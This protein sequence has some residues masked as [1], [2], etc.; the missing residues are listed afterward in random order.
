MN[1]KS[2]LGV[3][4]AWDAS[5]VTEWF[6]STSPLKLQIIPNKLG[7]TFRKRYLK[8][9]L[10]PTPAN[11][12]IGLT[13]NNLLIGVLGFS[14]FGGFQNAPSGDYDIF[15]IADTTPSE[16]DKS[17]DLLL[18]C[19]RTKEM[20]TILEKKFCRTIET[21]YSKCFSENQSINRYKKHAKL[22]HK[23]VLRTNKQSVPD[24]VKSRANYLV[25]YNLKKGIIKKQPCEV[26]GRTDYV[27]AH[28][29]DYEK[30]FEINWLCIEHH[31]ERDALDETCYKINGYALGYIF[32]A[33]SIVSLKEAKAQFIQKSW[34]K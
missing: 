15:L 30:P 10:I 11:F 17:T 20:K 27:E 31:N 34:K 9:F 32:K 8:G 19:L 4:V 24:K 13:Q 3:T 2:G 12:Y 18:F 26:C 28:H 1:K 5:S 29:K 33:G 14:G 21:I 25:N 22:I 16:W 6:D 7:M 23:K